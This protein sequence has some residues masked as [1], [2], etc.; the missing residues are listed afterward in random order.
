MV[1]IFRESK[2]TGCRVLA[3][4][5]MS[6]CGLE[7]KTDHKHSDKEFYSIGISYPCSVAVGFPVEAEN[8]NSSFIPVL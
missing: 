5:Y 2:L 4:C 3:V 1:I 8:M 7:E 6:V